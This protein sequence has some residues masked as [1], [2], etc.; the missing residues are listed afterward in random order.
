MALD[1][2]MPLVVTTTMEEYVGLTIQDIQDVAPEAFQARFKRGG[3]LSCWDDP[4]L[5]ADIQEKG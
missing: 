1:Y 2:A 3:E 5:E 4:A